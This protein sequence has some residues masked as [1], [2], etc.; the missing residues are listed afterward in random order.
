MLDACQSCRFWKS[1]SDFSERGRCRRYAPQ[2]ANQAI[3][4]AGEAVIAIADILSRHFGIEWP[5]GI[6]AEPTET[7]H[8]AMF[9]R[10]YCDEWCG[11]HQPNA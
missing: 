4:F 11:E 10:T 5:S 8:T 3:L 1:S 7:D 2:S 9:P 6:D